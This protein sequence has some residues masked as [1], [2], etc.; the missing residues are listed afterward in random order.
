MSLI[1]ILFSI[2][3][4]SFLIF[5][6]ELGHYIMA[7]RAG[8]TIEVFSIGM[9]KPIV[10]WVKNGVKWQICYLLFGGYVKIAGMEGEDGKEP[11]QIQGGF[12]SKKPLQRLLVA[13]A[14]PF[15]NIVFALILFTGI[16]FAGGEKKPFSQVTAIIGK[17]DPTSE[18]YSKGI[19]EGDV[20]LS[21]EGTP[22]ENFRDVLIQGMFKGKKEVEVKILSQSK[23]VVDSIVPL[24]SLEEHQRAEMFPKEWKSMGIL[25]PA[26][27]VIADGF[28]PLA[29]SFAPLKES[30]LKKGDQVVYVDG[31]IIYS[32]SQ[33]SAIINS[34]IALV[35]I[36]R[37]GKKMHIQVPRIVLGDLKLTDEQRDEFVDYK[38]EIDL[39][40]AFASTYFIP[41]LISEGLFIKE[42]LLFIDDEEIGKVPHLERGD[43][44][45]AVSG[46]A[47][48]NPKEFYKVLETRKCLVMVKEG[49]SED[50]LWK[51]A[52]KAFFEDVDKNE[53]ALMEERIGEDFLKSS[54]GY[55]FLTPTEPISYK[56]F[57]ERKNPEELKK[58]QESFDKNDY[59][60]RLA[61][62]T[63][64]SG[65]LLKDE[66][67][68]YNKGPFAQAK[69]VIKDIA[70]SFKGLLTGTISPKH[71]SGPIGMIKIVHDGSKSSIMTGLYWLGMISLNLGCMNLLPIPVLDG[72]HIC[73]TL[74]EVVT[75]KRIRA[76]TMQKMVIPFVALII[77][78]FV[79]VTFYDVIKV[80]NISV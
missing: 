56:S 19:R 14:G 23:G 38:R 62:K 8:M 43:R 80:F 18:L 4:L 68:I 72:G 79:Y 37:D 15:V 20:I 17:M 12:Y 73:F 30:S 25:A 27:F 1:S 16:Y 46:I 47:V 39:D 9:G 63:L 28:D 41:F 6:H 42:P 36:V 13:G 76:K 54:S 66:Q 40:G 34:D 71:M 35:T 70:F 65:V 77:F 7:K 60:K 44:I 49:P 32:V 50:V 33:L 21:I 57:L 64:F 52:D 75:K 59:E 11:Y 5:I 3:G 22:Y 26:S 51:D 55:R 24:Y 29:E 67:V 78:F 2:F 53:I 74:Y 61:Q 31:N 10:S 48:N 58:V 45:I 69:D